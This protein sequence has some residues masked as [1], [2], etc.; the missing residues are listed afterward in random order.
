MSFSWSFTNL[1]AKEFKIYPEYQQDA[2]LDFLDAYEEHGLSDFSKFPGKLT[3]S[4]SGLMATDPRY[5]Y[6]RDNALWHYHIGLPVYTQKQK[7]KT[8]DWV[9]HFQWIDKGTHIHV[10]DVCYHTTY[11]GEFYLPPPENLV[12]AGAPVGADQSDAT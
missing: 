2:I 12:G 8:S 7:Y 9:L 3:P 5:R 10:V 4:W 11:T 6:T 1:F